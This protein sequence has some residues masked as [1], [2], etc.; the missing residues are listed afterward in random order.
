M[1]K[2]LKGMFSSESVEWYS[3]PEIINP[4]T[5]FYDGKIDLDPASNEFFTTKAEFNYTWRDDGLKRSWLGKCYLNP[6]YG[7]NIKLW[8]QK[9][10]E[11]TK[12][13]SECIMLLP[14]RTDTRWFHDL[15]FDVVVLLK[16]RVNFVDGT[17]L[18]VAHSLNPKFALSCWHLFTGDSAA[19]PSM[20]T[21][22]V[23][24]KM[25]SGMREPLINKFKNKFS[26][27]GIVLER[28]VD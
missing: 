2:D 15:D 16:G 5:E 20:L 17:W 28:S 26:E 7:K 1:S 3:P 10:N 13:F 9:H 18:K 6:E 14:A 23:G 21:Y 12:N 19:F 22:K 27:M 25:P 24:S 8:T 4:V 11:E